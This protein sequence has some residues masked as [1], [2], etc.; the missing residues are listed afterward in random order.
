MD[1]DYVEFSRFSTIQHLNN[2]PK[3]KC[4][5]FCL[6]LRSGGFVSLFY[7]CSSFQKGEQ[8]RKRMIK[9]IENIKLPTIH[10]L[11]LQGNLIESME[12]LSMMELSSMKTIYLCT[13]ELYRSR[14]PF[15]STS[16]IRK[17]HWASL[18]VF[19]F[20]TYFLR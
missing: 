17:M 19:S 14:K 20:C 12:G 6:T 15:H 9:H 5:R 3:S 11:N 8:G 10:T 7:V 18:K 2:G 4:K 1:R 16:Q 13:S